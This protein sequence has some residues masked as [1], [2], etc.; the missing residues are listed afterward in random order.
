MS[1]MGHG[2]LDGAQIALAQ[3]ASGWRNAIVGLNKALK[4]I[5]PADTIAG[6]P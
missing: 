6:N 2:H 5:V 1:A 3:S 4:P